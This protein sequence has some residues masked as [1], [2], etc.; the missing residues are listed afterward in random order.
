[1]TV[2]VDEPGRHHQARGVHLSGRRGQAGT[3]L[4]DPARADGHVGDGVEPGL[5]IDYA[6][7]AQDQA[8]LAAFGGGLRFGHPPAPFWR[9]QV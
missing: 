3:D 1:M 8:S 2:Q 6:A 5:R 7:A 9:G 4:R